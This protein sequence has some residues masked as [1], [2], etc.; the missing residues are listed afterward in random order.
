MTVPVVPSSNHFPAERPD[1]PPA[2]PSTRRGY[3]RFL[4]D[5]ASMA[6]FWTIAYTPVFLYTSRSFEAV[7]IGL[8]SAAALEVL[9]GGV[10]G[11]FSD[12]FRVKMRAA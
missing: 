10:Y 12:W 4:V 3:R 9:L 7:L 8:A 5:A 11:R 1:D 6:I 2:P